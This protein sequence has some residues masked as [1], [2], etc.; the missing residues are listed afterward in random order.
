[1]GSS[2]ARRVRVVRLSRALKWG[3][4]RAECADGCSCAV[5]AVL[6]EERV[7]ELAAA[8][9]RT[10]AQL[11][12]TKVRHSAGWP[13]VDVTRVWHGMVPEGAAVLLAAGARSG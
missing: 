12:A 10:Q 4:L 11:E 6:L 1:M 2:S 5:S 7:G 9:Q 3:S 8:H 13:S